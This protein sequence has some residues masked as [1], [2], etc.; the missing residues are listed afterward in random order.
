MQVPNSVG[1]SGAGDSAFLTSSR[2]D[3]ETA[4]L[5]ATLGV[6]GPGTLILKLCFVLQSTLCPHFTPYDGIRF[7]GGWDPDISTLHASHTA[8]TGVQQ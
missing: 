2:V 7:P 3:A 4:G 8:V 6:K 1:L 5:L